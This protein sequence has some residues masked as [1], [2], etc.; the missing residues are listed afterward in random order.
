MNINDYVNISLLYLNSANLIK[1]IALKSDNVFNN[2]IQNSTD[3]SQNDLSLNAVLTK[4][5]QKC[6]I[7]SIDLCNEGLKYLKNI[8]NDSGYKTLHAQVFK[9]I[10][11]II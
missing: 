4:E 8:E 3:E 6:H 9:Y 10:L 7:Q 5:Q 2:I 11:V 1:Q